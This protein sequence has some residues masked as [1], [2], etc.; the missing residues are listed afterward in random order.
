[1]KP[2]QKTQL[3]LMLKDLKIFKENEVLWSFH[4]DPTY[5]ILIQRGR[6]L[7]IREKGKLENICESGYYIGEVESMLKGNKTKT[8][9]VC[10]E[11]GSAFILYKNEFLMFLN[12]N[13][14]LLVYFSDIEFCN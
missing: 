3:E 9:V 1:M 7:L 2:A 5:A 12:K 14:G 10:L 13:P 8:K 11:E 6:F 4:E